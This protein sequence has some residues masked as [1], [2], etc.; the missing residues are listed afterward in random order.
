M[1]SLL[2]FVCLITIF[3]FGS[4]CDLAVKQLMLKK[5]T[6][7]SL[8]CLK[9][10]A[11]CNEKCIFWEETSLDS[12]DFEFFSEWNDVAP[13]GLMRKAKGE[14][15]LSQLFRLV[16]SSEVL[17]IAINL[18][19]LNYLTQFSNSISEIPYSEI[20]LILLEL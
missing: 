11:K 18:S 13:P 17:L 9:K 10:S 14:W 4:Y 15:M 6:C 19:H 1:F 7:L 3:H 5:K 12:L 20:L 16:D 2:G 8:F